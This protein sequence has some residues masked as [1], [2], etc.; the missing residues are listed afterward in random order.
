MTGSASYTIKT[1]QGR[2][3]GELVPSR[4]KDGGRIKRWG[5]NNLLPNDID[6]I[7]CDNHITGEMMITK[8]EI[9]G[10]QGISAYVEKVD[11]GMR[12]RLPVEM[13]EDIE[14]WMDDV[15]FYKE[16]YWPAINNLVKLQ[17]NF[18]EIMPAHNG[19]NIGAV[20]ARENKHCRIG[21]KDENGKV[22]RYYLS[23]DWADTRKDVL[24]RNA[25]NGKVRHSIYHNGDNFFNDGYYNIPSWMGSLDFIQLANAIAKF[26]MSNLSNGYSLRYHIQIPVD[27]FLD[28]ESFEQAAGDKSAEQKCIDAARARKEEFL[29]KLNEI[30]AGVNNA[31]RTITTT[32]EIDQL[33][34]QHKGIKIEP[35]DA[36]MKDEALIK[37][38]DKVNQAVI[39]GQG[40]HPTMANIESQGKLSSGSEMRNAFNFWVAIKTRTYRMHVM[41]VWKIIAKANGWDR[42]IDPSTGKRIR[43]HVEDITLAKLDEDKS[44]TS[45]PVVREGAAEEV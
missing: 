41:E 30:L 22:K 32:Y 23:G 15:D 13:P 44:G 12:T 25:W 11:K 17:N 2:D 18:T 39:S 4:A 7:L 36:D 24:Y 26:H 38:L 43:Y 10:G 27:Y 3:I 16:Y 19:K 42:L 28:H 31:G 45:S 21:E 9:I 20:K 8:R 33:T 6:D 14:D 5:G 37:L 40:I 29:E 35:I 1:L 34:K